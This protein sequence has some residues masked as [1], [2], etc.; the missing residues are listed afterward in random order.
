MS[1]FRMEA[2][3]FQKAVSPVRKPEFPF[4]F[5]L[6][7]TVLLTCSAYN[8]PSNFSAPGASRGWRGAGPLI[9]NGW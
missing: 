3:G 7:C 2:Y 4:D 9:S 8:A 6:S 5:P 1:R